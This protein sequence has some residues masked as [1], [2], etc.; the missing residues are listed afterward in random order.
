[1]TAILTY[2]SV[3]ESDN[4]PL[5]ADRVHNIPP[6]LL[7]AQLKFLK[8]RF[9]ILPLD[10]L[11]ERIKRGK[12]TNGLA[13]VTFDD[14][15]VSVLDYGIPVLNALGISATFFLSTRLIES[16]TFWRDK[17]RYLINTNLVVDFLSY[18]SEINPAFSRVT[19]SRFYSETKDPKIVNSKVVEDIMDDYLS[20]AG[21]Q[22]ESIARRVYCSV[23][24]FR[25]IPSDQLV[26]GNHGHSHY[27][28][29]SMTMDEQYEDIVLG[30]K[31]IKNFELPVSSVFS[32][33]FGTPRDFNKD[34]LNILRDLGYVCYVLST[35]KGACDA[36]EGGGSYALHDGL[37]AL[38]RFMPAEDMNFLK[39]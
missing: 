37:L 15:Y 10:E 33:P 16:Q 6:D 36:F 18:A 31:L 35:G 22:M 14:G 19:P 12:T 8:K 9:T 4:N 39:T 7:Y 32:I 2:H 11:V 25:K 26:V 20:S 24:D 29:S 27:V 34:T 17:V 23:E 5:I 28:L 38:S 13:S 30:K 1:M 3:Y 21:I